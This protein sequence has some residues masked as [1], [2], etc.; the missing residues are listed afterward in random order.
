LEEPRAD[1]LVLQSAGGFYRLMFFIMGGENCSG[2]YQL[3]RLL[4][5][6]GDR[7]GEVPVVKY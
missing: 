1:K 6:D 5:G 2:G 3:V 4:I 7:V